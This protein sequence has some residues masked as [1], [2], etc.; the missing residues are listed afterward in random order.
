VDLEEKVCY[1]VDCIWLRVGQMNQ[2]RF[3]QIFRVN[4]VLL[5]DFL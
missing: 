2:D 4:H 3:R 5:R 1:D